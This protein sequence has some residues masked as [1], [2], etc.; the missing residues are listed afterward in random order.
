MFKHLKVFLNESINLEI[1][2]CILKWRLYFTIFKN[3]FANSFLIS[4]I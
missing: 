1:D 4:S 2:K 3:A